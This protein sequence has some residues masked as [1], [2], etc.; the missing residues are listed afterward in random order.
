MCG[1]ITITSAIIDFF[2]R[3]AIII[4]IYIIQIIMG[5]EIVTIL[6]YIWQKRK[7]CITTAI[8]LSCL[9][10]LYNSYT[11]F[12]SESCVIS[13]IY[14]NSEKGEYP[15]S[16][17]LNIYDIISDE[18]LEETAN[19]YNENFET[20]VVNAK[21]IKE[22]ITVREFVSSTLQERVESARS[23]GQDYFYFANEFYVTCN[24]VKGFRIKDWKH[25]F[26]LIPNVNNKLL[27]ECLYD[28]YIMYFMNEHTE[29]NIIPRLVA[30]IDYT[31]YDYLEIA[32]VL[33]NKIDMYINYLDVKNLENGSFVSSKTGMTF[34]ALIVEFQ[35][36]R[37]LQVNS[38]KAFVSSSKLAKHPEEFINKLKAQNEGNMVIYKKLQG[39]AEVAKTA[40]EQ[41]DHTFEENIVM[42]GV[43][44][45]LGLYQARV[46]TAYDIITKRAL[47]KGVEAKYKLKDIQQNEQ[48][49]QEYNADILD[50]NERVRLSKAADDMI[51]NI[52]NA[53]AV[54]VGNASKTVDDFLMQKSS[55]YIRETKIN[56]NYI[57]INILVKLVV[58]F[59]LGNVFALFLS[60]V[61][62]VYRVYIKSIAKKIAVQNERN[63][64]LK[65]LANI[66][67]GDKVTQLDDQMIED[68]SMEYEKNDNDKSGGDNR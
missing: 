31:N 49:M 26:G 47:N 23:S 48:F 40:M 4:L 30:D 37:D 1:K 28:S 66:K 18:V 39:E 15:D 58:V 11:V 12:F 8:I 60:F 5:D 20:D 36:L 25:L 9:F 38:L 55:D 33:T 51:I 42:T 19:K 13:F 59:V 57:S 24:P 41:Y 52:E 56:K 54:L 53:N 32:D 65:R 6:T 14:P 34:N 27:M 22:I 62:R 50:P 68:L 63:M 3:Y 44:D 46:K 64:A 43:N 16:T 45:E 10:L 35:T 61:I 67:S 17:R 21:Q 7:I 2:D 29:M